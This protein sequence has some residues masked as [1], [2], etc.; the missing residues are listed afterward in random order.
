MN[1]FKVG[2]LGI[3]FLLLFSGAAVGLGSWSIAESPDY[4]DKISS[5]F[6]STSYLSPTDVWAVGKAGNDLN[7][8]G[9]MGI[10]LIQHYD[11]AQW[12]I[13]E[14][15]LPANSNVV[16]LNDIETISPNDVWAVGSYGNVSSAYTKTLIEHWD[17]EKWSIIPSPDQ[18]AG[19]Y[20]SELHALTSVNGKSNDIWAVGA[21]YISINQYPILLHWDGSTWTSSKI[22]VGAGN[23][24]LYDVVA[25]SP[26]DVWAVGNNQSN[27]FFSIHFNGARWS[28]VN[29]PSFSFP[30][31]FIQLNSVSAASKNDIWVSGFTY[32]SLLN[33][34]HYTPFIGHWNGG[35]WENVTAKFNSDQ[36]F[37]PYSV[38]FT[39]GGI[40]AIGPND[41]WVFGNKFD[42]NLGSQAN[43]QHW[44]G[45]KWAESIVQ[46]P[47]GYGTI[48][49]LDG[50]D[51]SLLGVGYYSNPYS[52][53]LN[54]G[55]HTLVEKYNG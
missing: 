12:S 45:T 25:I 30:V 4:P 1:F 43:L 16:E 33:P 2:I 28:V 10:P 40:K 11:G 14:A 46:Q 42:P 7:P 34:Y 20:G 35:Q 21:Y 29:G 54:L 27:T 18:P 22:P 19:S 37:L 55:Q 23:G 50:V 17:G 15:A 26:R 39:T 13:V 48:L 32:G 49:D 5:I 41:V 36:P 9:T 6:T 24:G 52:Y 31:N 47:A 53:P 38:A 51:G 8:D 44:D 3:F